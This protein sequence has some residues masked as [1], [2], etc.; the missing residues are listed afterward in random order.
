MNKN[1]LIKALRRNTGAY[2]NLDEYASILKNAKLFKISVANIQH[3]DSMSKQ[4]DEISRTR[5]INFPFD[6][7]FIDLHGYQTPSLLT[8]E[9]EVQNMGIH[10]APMAFDLKGI[11]VMSLLVLDFRCY[12]KDVIYRTHLIYSDMA[13]LHV[14]SNVDSSSKD[15]ECYMRNVFWMNPN[16]RGEIQSRI[17]CHKNDVGLALPDCASIG[18]TCP[19]TVSQK[20]EISN[21]IRVLLGYM[22]LP[23]N[24][25]F[26]V[27]KTTAKKKP[28]EHF[29]L[30]D[31]HQIDLIMGG[32]TTAEIMGNGFTDG[33][34]LKFAMDK[35]AEEPSQKRF[36]VGEKIYEFFPKE[37]SNG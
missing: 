20:S 27:V 16:F 10:M 15:C 24:H 8:G 17:P 36:R 14:M 31:N 6:N 19:R 28:E 22:T 30:A 23:S 11:S 32:D 34:T 1:Q 4:F 26:K 3:L 18:Q 37:T 9:V 5:A 25:I 7:I 35:E 13:G 2:E 33:S 29:I 12:G 21:L